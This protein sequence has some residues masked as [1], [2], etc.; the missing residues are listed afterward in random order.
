MCVHTLL[1]IKDKWTNAKD[2][3]REYNDNT[4]IS[5]K[6]EKKNMYYILL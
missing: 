4:R 1:L 3:K 2:K 6:V 5:L